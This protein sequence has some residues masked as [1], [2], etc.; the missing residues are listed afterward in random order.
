V[1][2]NAISAFLAEPAAPDPPARVWRDWVLLAI[3]VVTA[4]L[5]TIFRE[6]LVW[7]P[8]GLVACLT[9]AVALLWRRTHPLLVS[10][11]A[12]GTASVLDL[13]ARLAT[14]EPTAVLFTTAFAL[15]LPYSL[16][17]W[18]SGRQA[19]IGIGL[20]L[21]VNVVVEAAA[22]NFGDLIAGAAFFL[23]AAAIGA[24]VRYRTSTKQRE[25]EQ[26]TLRER[27]Q[28]ARELHD[29]V[30]HHVSAIAVRAQAGR[31]LA[32]SQPTA[33]VDALE[34][35][36]EAASRTL[37]EL[38]AI[39]ATL[40]DGEEAELA[41]SRGV[42]DIPRLA[43]TTD[44]PRV[45]VELTGD[46]QG[47]RPM[48][49]AAAYRIAQESITNAVRHARHATRIDVR[50]IGEQECVIVVVLDDGEPGAVSP[51]GYGLAGM[52]ERAALLGGTL[53]AGPSAGGGWLVTATLPRSGA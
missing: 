3:M 32:A 4:T 46:L 21:G 52:T 36:E 43:T 45:D 33:A 50:V 44:G 16:L 1:T 30:A 2:S 6:D 26:I 25:R 48:V 28:L 42:T 20:L 22:G 11:I 47:L 10:V 17:R 51:L 18:G 53:E 8:V 37:T 13:V 41:P 39:V 27:E 5:E 38:R 14:D 34:V 12:F 49:G 9:L 35:I 24:T 31:A 23:L 19:A 40:R 29:A 15:L 7:Q